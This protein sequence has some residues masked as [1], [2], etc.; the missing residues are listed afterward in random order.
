[1][2][3]REGYGEYGESTFEV[4]APAR[5]QAFTRTWWGRGWVTA[6]EDGVLDSA[7]IRA[8]RRLARGGA[9]GAV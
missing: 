8:G 6:L 1:M 5:G 7:Q 4:A 2:S 9:V 3:G